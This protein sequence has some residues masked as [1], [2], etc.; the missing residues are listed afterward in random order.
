MMGMAQ[1]LA[2]LAYTKTRMVLEYWLEKTVME[3][4]ERIDQDMWGS[5][6]MVP[7]S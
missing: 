3:K 5:G 1:H 4:Q 6:P 2:M 7:E